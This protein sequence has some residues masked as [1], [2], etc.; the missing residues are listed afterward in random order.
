MWW[1][2]SG[3][4]V[5]I[6]AVKTSNARSGGACTRTLWRTATPS[7]CSI[8]LSLLLLGGIAKSGQRLVPERVEVGPQVGQRLR[9]HLVEPARADL[10]VG[11]QPGVLED[12][13]VLR[14]R[15]TA[16]R[17]PVGQLADRSRPR[18]QALEDGLARGVPERGHRSSYVSHG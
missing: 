2:A 5:L 18:H 8:I 15:R 17:K 4:H 1:D 16:D 6:P 7:A 11:H 9:I 13:E 3:H 10:A 12:L 14:D